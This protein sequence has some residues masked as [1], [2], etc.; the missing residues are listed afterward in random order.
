MSRG[1]DDQQTA[2]GQR[3]WSLLDA[4]TAGGRSITLHWVPGHADLAGNEAA[5]RL[6]NK[7]AADCAQEAAPIDISSARTAIRR[8]TSELAAVRAQRH[9][10]RP[11]T[12][13][14]GELDRWGQVT[15]SQL[16]TGYCPLVRAIAHRLGLVKDPTC[17]ACGEEAEDVEHLLVGCPAHVAARAGF[18]GHFPTLAEVL[19]GP[20]QKIMDFI[21]RV[22]RTEVPTDPPPPAAP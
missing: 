22:G 11:P 14:H 7:A 12:P 21:K 13:D 15:L 6:A 4:L 8:W 10:H 5:D 19:S 2:I 20:A 3:V 9:P 16:R 18:W 17:R 1:P